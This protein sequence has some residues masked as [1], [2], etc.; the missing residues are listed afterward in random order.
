MDEKLT[1]QELKALCEYFFNEGY[2][3]R[4]VLHTSPGGREARGEKWSDDFETTFNK[5][6]QGKYDEAVKAKGVELWWYEMQR[7]IERQMEDFDREAKLKAH[8]AME[9][10]RNLVITS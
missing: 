8:Q 5:L 6:M 1:I 9:D 4:H 3:R 2:N 7:E 10:L